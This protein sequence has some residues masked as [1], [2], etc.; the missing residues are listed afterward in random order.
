[1][2]GW[3]SFCRFLLLRARPKYSGDRTRDDPPPQIRLPAGRR[4]ILL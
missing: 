2:V 4:A 1:M 3:S